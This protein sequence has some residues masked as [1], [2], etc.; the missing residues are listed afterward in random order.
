MGHTDEA[1]LISLT[2]FIAVDNH[3]EVREAAI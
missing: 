3:L 2:D 1:S